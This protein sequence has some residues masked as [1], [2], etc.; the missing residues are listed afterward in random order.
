MTGELHRTKRINN[1]FHFEV[2]RITK[3][4]LSAGFPIKFIRN[5]IEYFDKDKDDFIIPKWL[6]D[7]RKTTVFRIK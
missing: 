1:N 3:K 7:E 2:K 6:F 4:F 5:I